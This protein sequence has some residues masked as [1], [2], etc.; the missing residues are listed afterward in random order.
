MLIRKP[1]IV[2]LA[3]AALAV[4]IPGIIYIQR[5]RHDPCTHLSRTELAERYPRLAELLAQ[6]SEESSRLLARQRTQDF[7]MNI[8]MNSKQISLEEALKA[9]TQQVDEVAAMR[10]RHRQAF[11]AMCRKIVDEE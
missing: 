8:E 3:I 2:L 6:Q 7:E 9:S 5:E 10:K 1:L 11:N 4:A